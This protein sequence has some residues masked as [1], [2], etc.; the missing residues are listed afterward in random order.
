MLA[1]LIEF[2]RLRRLRAN[3][4]ESL[5]LREYFATNHEVE[6]GLYTYGCF[7]RWRVPRR[8]R[9]GRYCSFAK[10]AR[11]LDANHP[12]EALTTHPYLYEARFGVVPK[13]LI[14]P[15]WLEISDDVWISHNVTIT[16]GCK[17]IGRGAII[18]AGAIVTRDVPAYTIM[19]GAP[20]RAIRP[21]FAPETIAALEASRWWTLDKAALATLVRDHPHAAYHPDP[22]SLAAI[23]TNG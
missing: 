1:K 18:G 22:A 3:E 11:I 15:P 16:P 2:I 23:T 21:R 12:I 14:D 20:A 9:I 6:V 17:A 4:Y 5:E 10:T 13:D 19:A 8:T 7:D